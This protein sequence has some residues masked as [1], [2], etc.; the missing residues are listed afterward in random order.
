MSN[1]YN[2]SFHFVNIKNRIDAYAI[3]RKQKIRIQEIALNIYIF[4]LNGIQVDI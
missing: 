1:L 4:C 3:K 2:I